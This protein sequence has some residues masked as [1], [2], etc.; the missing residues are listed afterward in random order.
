VCQLP[1]RGVF[2]SSAAARP[3]QL[4]FKGPGRHS[5]HAWNCGLA[6]IY[7]SSRFLNTSD[8]RFLLVTIEEAAVL[9]MFVSAQ[10]APAPF[11]QLTSTYD[12]FCN[13]AGAEPRSDRLLRHER[14]CPGR[15]A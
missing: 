14:H 10:C 11:P 9:L 2:A 8:V 5:A 1:I 3:P 4:A 6:F 15:S 13:P 7:F 12:R